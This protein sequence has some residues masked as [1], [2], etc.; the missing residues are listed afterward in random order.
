MIKGVDSINNLSSIAQTLVNQGYRFVIRYYTNPANLKRVTIAEVSTLRSAG[1]QVV[2]VYQ[3]SHN[4]Y[5][6]FSADIARVNASEAINQAR[7][8][9]QPSGTIYFAVD[10]DASASEIDANI[11]AHFRVLK[12]MLYQAGY[13]VGVYGSGL[14]CRKLKENLNVSRTWLSMSS[15]WRESQTY[16]DWDIKQTSKKT[17]GGI[18]V[19]ENQADSIYDLGGW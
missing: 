4:S 18:C 17:I 6:K 8:L 19:D 14:V 11:T 2:P 15:G 10:Y 9:G 7:S 13:G 1:L 12:D 5:D 3:N 16:N